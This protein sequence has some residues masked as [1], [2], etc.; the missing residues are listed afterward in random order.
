MGKSLEIRVERDEATCPQ[1]TELSFCFFYFLK[2]GYIN[3]GK[4][5]VKVDIF[6]QINV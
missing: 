3:I 2:L 4:Q 5:K 6:V 1:D